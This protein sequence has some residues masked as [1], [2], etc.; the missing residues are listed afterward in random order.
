MHAAKSALSES[1][2]VVDKNKAPVDLPLVFSAK[3]FSLNYSFY[4]YQRIYTTD[5]YGLE[6]KK[7]ITHFLGNIAYREVFFLA[8]S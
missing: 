8:A 7:T 2:I 6:K 5:K 3:M 4:I 1:F